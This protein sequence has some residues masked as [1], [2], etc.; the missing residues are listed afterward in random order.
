MHK[1]TIVPILLKNSW[2]NC[3]LKLAK[4]R[5]AKRRLHY[6][7][8]LLYYRWLWSR[9][10]HYISYGSNKMQSKQLLKCA[11]LLLNSVADKY[12]DVEDNEARTAMHYAIEYDNQECVHMIEL[13]MFTIPA[14]CYDA[15]F[16]IFNL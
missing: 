3:K 14:L 1:P 9:T 5:L 16:I 10:R 7:S 2:N 6:V 13:A 12:H 4:R 8:Y 15:W 11:Q